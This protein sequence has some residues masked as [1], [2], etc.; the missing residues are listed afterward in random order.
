MLCVAVITF[1]LIIFLLP[2]TLSSSIFGL[3]VDVCLKAVDEVQQGNNGGAQ[4]TGVDPLMKFFRQKTHILWDKYNLVFEQKPTYLARKHPF[5]ETNTIWTNTVWYLNT[6]TKDW[7]WP[8]DEVLWPEK[9]PAP[10]GA[11]S[12]LWPGKQS[13]MELKKFS[14]NLSKRAR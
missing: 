13:W 8:P 6:Y 2:P 12:S 9:H 10:P 4:E 3:F 1:W 7:C 11:K 14:E 5:S